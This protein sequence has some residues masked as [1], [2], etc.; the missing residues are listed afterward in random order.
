L[1]SETK[2]FFGRLSGASRMGWFSRTMG[3]F[4]HISVTTEV[5]VFF[6]FFFFFF[7]LLCHTELKTVAHWWKF[8]ASTSKTFS[9][10]KTFDSIGRRA[11]R[12]RDSFS[13]FQKRR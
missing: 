11:W 4:V 10:A 3:A 13:E 9:H 2:Q 1:K 8:L 7:S 12:M 5:F 6:A